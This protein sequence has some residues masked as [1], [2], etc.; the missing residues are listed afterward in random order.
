[1]RRLAIAV[2]VLAASL[3][4]DSSEPEEETSDAGPEAVSGAPR[5]ELSGGDR[6]KVVSVIVG[7]NVDITLQTIGPG[8]YGDPEVSSDN[9]RFQEVELA[10]VQN[11]GGPTQ[12][13]H[14]ECAAVGSAMIM[15]SHTG[16][17]EAFTV[18]LQCEEDAT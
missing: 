10:P 17:R 14:F 18:T 2:F 12:I 1:M 9:V 13:F 3:G 11:P 4:C 8:Q 6:G 16:G 15:I 5:V 7:R